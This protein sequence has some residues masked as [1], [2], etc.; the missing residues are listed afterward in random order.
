MPQPAALNFAMIPSPLS[1]CAHMH[2]GLRQ[3]RH[4]QKSGRPPHSQPEQYD[5]PLVPHQSPAKG[6][7]PIRPGTY[8]PCGCAAA[9]LK[10][11]QK[12]AF[13]SSGAR[14]DQLLGSIRAHQ[15]LCMVSIDLN[16]LIVY[17][18]TAH[19]ALLPLNVAAVCAQNRVFN[20]VNFPDFPI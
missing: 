14:R 2:A 3:L 7:G 12:V 16:K 4:H 15:S 11:G 10:S 19:I 1:W 13:G 9:V 20:L 18:I 17:S 8:L 5:L 6:F